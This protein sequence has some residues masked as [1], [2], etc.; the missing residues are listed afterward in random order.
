M[1]QAQIS[2]TLTTIP[3]L[4]N[5][6]VATNYAEL[7]VLSVF[8]KSSYNFCRWFFDGQI[9]QTIEIISP[10]TACED[11]NETPK[12]PLKCFISEG[13][14]NTTLVL[15]FALEIDFDIRT[16][17]SYSV[18]DPYDIQASANFNVISKYNIKLVSYF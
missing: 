11:R 1:A 16:E 8:E 14:I 7:Q 4:P 2:K 3:N 17:C 5:G 12:F 10:D 18:I 9:T 6:I 15:S 13:I